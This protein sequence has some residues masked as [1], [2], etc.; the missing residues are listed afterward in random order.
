MPPSP[1]VNSSP[2]LE[3]L[4]SMVVKQGLS[5]GLLSEGQRD[6]AL[7]LAASALPKAVACSEAEVNMALRRCLLAEA[8]FLDTDHVELRRWLVDSGYC[9]RDG[10]GRSYERV[11]DADLTPARRAAASALAPLDLPSWVA[12]QQSRVRDQRQARHQAWQ[13]RQGASGV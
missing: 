10:F 8:A 6:L 5:I 13:A 2:T 11:A 7:A 4:A 9:R 1:T 12:A 3:L